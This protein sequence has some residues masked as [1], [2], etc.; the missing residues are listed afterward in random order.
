M[1]STKKP[2]AP[3]VPVRT[4][5]NQWLTKKAK[6]DRLMVDAALIGADLNAERESIAAEAQIDLPYVTVG[7]LQSNAP[8]ITEPP[9]RRQRQSF[10]HFINPS[11]GD[12]PFEAPLVNDDVITV[13]SRNPNS[14]REP[15]DAE[16]ASLDA[17]GHVQRP[18]SSTPYIDPVAADLDRD[19][20]VN[21]E[22]G[23]SAVGGALQQAIN[24]GHRAV[25]FG[26]N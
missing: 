21:G 15:T 12:I 5:I 25:Q 8:A 26:Q 17:V 7:D 24:N 20:L 10:R 14:R 11:A 19:L 4:R 16:L 23:P 3:K 13:R 6:F 22:F 1:A 2:V 9:A 18:V